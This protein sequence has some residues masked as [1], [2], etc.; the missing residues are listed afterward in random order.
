[1]FIQG[2][3]S[4][5][6]TADFFFFLFCINFYSVLRTPFALWVI[7]GT[8]FVL[9]KWGP[10]SGGSSSSSQGPASGWLL[11]LNKIIH[12][13]FIRLPPSY[14]FLPCCPSGMGSWEGMS[15]SDGPEDFLLGRD[16]SK[17]GGAVGESLLSV[18]MTSS[19]LSMLP[20]RGFFDLWQCA[21]ITEEENKKYLLNSFFFFPFK[22][23]P[24][25]AKK[26]GITASLPR[27]STT[28][29]KDAYL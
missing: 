11:T 27:S 13:V 6:A 20:R 3:E 10:M 4:Q 28:A 26:G 24:T 18:V 9:S 23:I 2:D 14:S 17:V 22:F 1:M 25:C 5:I 19:T 12:A 29:V 15:C 8:K 21:V 7:T 16:G